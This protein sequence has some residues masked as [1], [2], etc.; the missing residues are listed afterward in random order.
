M[1]RTSRMARRW[2]VRGAY[3]IQD[4]AALWVARIDGC[5]TNVVGLPLARLYQLTRDLYDLSG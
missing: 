4:V 5:Y 2:T 1:R 3:G